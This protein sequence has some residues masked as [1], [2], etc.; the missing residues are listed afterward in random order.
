MDAGFTLAEHEGAFCYQ[1]TAAR[2]S[3]TDR[4]PPPPRSAPGPRFPHGPS[5]GASS[6]YDRGLAAFRAER[7]TEA[8]ALMAAVIRSSPAF[9]PA[10]LLLGGVYV[11]RGRYDE[12]FAQAEQVLRENDLEPH[13]H[14]LVGMIAARRGQA[15]EAQQALRRALYLDDSLALAHFWL[16]NLY[17]DQGDI[18]KACVEYESVVRGW[19]RH[20]LELTE[21]FASDLNAVELVDFCQRSLQRLAPSERQRP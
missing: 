7:W 10:R 13:A 19:E 21:V 8:E 17:R 15:D 5:D 4:R 2:A 1:K 3:T 9:V 16:G 14:L 18:G 11:H 20:A 12:A 6:E